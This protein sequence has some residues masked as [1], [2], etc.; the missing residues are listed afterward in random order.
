MPVYPDGFGDPEKY[1]KQSDATH[2]L[3]VQAS[4]LEYSDEKG[5]WEIA[6]PEALATAAEKILQAQSKGRF[7]LVESSLTPYRSQET[8]CIRF[9][10][11]FEE[12]GNPR[13]H[14]AMF[15]INDKGFYCR[16]PNSVKQIV[17]VISSERF[18]REEEPF[19]DESL[20]SEVDEFFKQVIFTPLD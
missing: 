13:A 20:Q 1:K 18:V 4:N 5:V 3:I 11:V 15:I 9:T 12:E 2:T 17:N 8:D 16:H 19:S 14:G 6:S 10:A 7:R